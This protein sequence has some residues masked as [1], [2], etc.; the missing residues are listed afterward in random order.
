MIITDQGLQPKT[1]ADMHALRDIL[2]VLGGYQARCWCGTLCGTL[3][4][5]PRTREEAMGRHQEH[6][7][8]TK[9]I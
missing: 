6:H 1:W 9:S 5:P 3:T 2:K 4:S 7:D 8:E